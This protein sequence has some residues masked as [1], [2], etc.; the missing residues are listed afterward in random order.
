MSLQVTITKLG[1]TD[2]FGAPLA[3]GT[4]TAINDQY[5]IDL[6]NQGYATYITSTTG[7]RVNYPYV[8]IFRGTVDPV[9]GDGRPNGTV[10]IK[11][12]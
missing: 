12:T 1:R 8:P 6:V 9:N 5:A 2:E 11:T 4:F 3:L 10:Y 7:A